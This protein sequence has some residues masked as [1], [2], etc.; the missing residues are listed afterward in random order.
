MSAAKG[1][2]LGD[3]MKV[4]EKAARSTLPL[5]MP[6]IIRVDGKAFHTATRSCS[7]PFDHDLSLAMNGTAVALC[8]GIQGAAFAYVQS[9]EISIL[10]HNYR[11]LT[12]QAWFGN[13]VQKMVSISAAIATATF[14]AEK[15]VRM[16]TCLFDARVFVL[17][18]AEVANYF[19]WRQQDAI[20]NA[21]QMIARS[22][23]SHRE[24]D[25]KSCPEL[26]E[27]IRGVG[28]SLESFRVEH[29]RGRSVYRGTGE[30]PWVVDTNMPIL[31]EDR[32][33][34]EKWLAVDETV[35]KM[36]DRQSE[37]VQ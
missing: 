25:R 3:R 14:N 17:P 32:A 23:F 21:T 37:A 24:C 33:H 22:F 36:I 29:R 5:R 35:Q 19:V 30:S 18:E 26:V 20:R 9:D 1:D 7:R 27:M 12:T 15:P 10:V 2:A 28:S 6:V 4:Y 13:Q 11:T 34:V 31:T 8:E 16:P